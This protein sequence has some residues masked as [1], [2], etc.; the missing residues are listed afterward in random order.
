VRIE[1][2]IN[3]MDDYSK[4]IADLQL[5]IDD[6]VEAEGD[7]RAIAELEMQLDILKAIY[8]RARDLFVR[9]RSATG[10]RGALAIR[11]YGDWTLD[12]VY[13]F[14]YETAVELPA[15]GHG[16]FLGEISDTDFAGLLEH[17]DTA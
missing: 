8:G 6:M 4:E 2:K 7:P 13:A 9:G 1:A 5:Q 17:R 11:G 15:K 16:S 10:L 3:A 12:N 14:V